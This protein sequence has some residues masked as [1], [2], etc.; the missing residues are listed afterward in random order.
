MYSC[1]P[2]ISSSEFKAP[3]YK[4]LFPLP[5]ISPAALSP[6]PP[7]PPLPS[8]IV[9]GQLP[10]STVS[11]FAGGK[12]CILDALGQ[13]ARWDGGAVG[14]LGL[15]RTVKQGEEFVRAHELEDTDFHFCMMVQRL[16]W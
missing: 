10:R 4:Y 7:A 6:T 14:A 2:P 3:A 11:F 13:H 16:D 1:A 12:V 9:D 5:P 15:R 8:H